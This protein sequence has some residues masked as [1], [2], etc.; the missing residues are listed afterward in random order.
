MKPI[1]PIK[2]WRERGCSNTI[3]IIKNNGT[4]KISQKKALK[5]VYSLAKTN[6]HNE[7]LII[8]ENL[9]NSDEV[10]RQKIENFRKIGE[11]ENALEIFS[12]IRNNNSMIENQSEIQRP[13]KKKIRWIKPVEH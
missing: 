9:E 3:K 11:Y 6:N 7:A 12:E 4:L 2:E 13:L 8:L 10:A 5:L 1:V